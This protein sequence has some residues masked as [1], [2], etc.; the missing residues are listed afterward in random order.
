MP[1]SRLDLRSFVCHGE[2]K[3]PPNRCRS[4]P[5]HTVLFYARV[6]LAANTDKV[7]SPAAF[8]PSNTA[9]FRVN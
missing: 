4:Y 8:A 9:S 6:P 3:N 5:E 1:R 2:N 7:E